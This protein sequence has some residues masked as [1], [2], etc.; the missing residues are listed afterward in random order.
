MRVFADS[1]SLECGFFFV[2]Q[3]KEELSLIVSG[4]EF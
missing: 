4:T 1:G 3:I 2:L